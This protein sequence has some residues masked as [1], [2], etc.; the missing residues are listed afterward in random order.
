M[1]K[2]GDEVELYDARIGAPSGPKSTT[3]VPA[4]IEIEG[5]PGTVINPEGKSVSGKQLI[6]VR[7]GGG[8]KSPAY[9]LGDCD[10]SCWR[11]TNE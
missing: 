11:L 8:G 10:L 2:I 4:Y 6:S 5:K 9:F 3:K 1:F 7:I